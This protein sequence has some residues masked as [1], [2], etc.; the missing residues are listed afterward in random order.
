MAIGRQRAVV[1]G[2]KLA[3]VITA[4]GWMTPGTG[5]GPFGA[6]ASGSA[7][8]LE[9]TPGHALA[10]AQTVDVS[11]TG[12]PGTSTIVRQCLAAPVGIVD[13]DPGTATTV[14]LTADGSLSTRLRVFGDDVICGLAGR[15]VVRRHGGDDLVLGSA[16]DDRLHRGR[17]DDRLAGGP[18]RD[19]AYGGGG[20][21]TCEAEI[22]RSCSRPAGR[23][24]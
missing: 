23:L 18:G 14:A 10:D 22:R 7:P 4:V 2:L 19:H 20:D 3:L 6:A 11:G 8:A 21:D 9:V 5:L 13:C 12:L 1:V 24:W 17:G 16:G 15:D